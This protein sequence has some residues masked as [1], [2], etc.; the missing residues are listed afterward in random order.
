ME[1]LLRSPP[2]IP[3][4]EAHIRGPGLGALVATDGAIGTAKERVEDVCEGALPTCGEVVEGDGHEE[5]GGDLTHNEVGAKAIH[6]ALGEDWDEADVD[7][8]VE[9][10]HEARHADEGDLAHDLRLAASL[11]PTEEHKE[12]ETQKG[13]AKGDD[14]AARGHAVDENGGRGPS[15][16]PT[17]CRTNRPGGTEAS[18]KK[19][20]LKDFFFFFSFFFEKQRKQSKT[21]KTQLQAQRDVVAL[22]QHSGGEA[23]NQDIDGTRDCDVHGAKRKVSPHRNSC[24]NRN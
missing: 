7:T 14:E 1:T 15:H 12:L 22:I 20:E 3:A 16:N 2:T 6:V 19:I 18:A 8:L 21:G 24:P 23:P 5:G 9:K 10:A 4:G 11:Q 13:K 17:Q